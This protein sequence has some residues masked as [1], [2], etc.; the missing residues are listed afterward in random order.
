[1]QRGS[2]MLLFWRPCPFA[3]EGSQTVIVGMY[4]EVISSAENSLFIRTY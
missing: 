2:F 3:D 1:M 4:K